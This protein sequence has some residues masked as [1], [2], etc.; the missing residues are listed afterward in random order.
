MNIEI[1]YER[2]QY[3]IHTEPVRYAGT[4]QCN[5]QKNRFHDVIPCELFLAVKSHL[6]L[7]KLFLDYNCVVDKTR[8]KLK[9]V[10]GV[11][12]SDYVNANFIEVCF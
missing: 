4:L 2:I 11:G 1:E 8:C 3:T 7:H 9:A 6:L 12:G 5:L 10:H